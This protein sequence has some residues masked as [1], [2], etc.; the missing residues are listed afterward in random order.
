MKKDTIEQLAE[1]IDNLCQK[2]ANVKNEEKNKDK[3]TKK[4]DWKRF[5]ANV[6]KEK[7]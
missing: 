1:D 7:I 4:K 5:R 2:V 6:N 3:F